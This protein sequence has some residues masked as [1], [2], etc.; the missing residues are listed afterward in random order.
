MMLQDTISDALMNSV[1]Q[2]SSVFANQGHSTNPRIGSN[3]ISLYI[4]PQMTPH[5]LIKLK[6]ISENK[7]TA[8]TMDFI[9]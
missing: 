7:I 3:G 9:I 4:Q 8:I 2:R 6:L 1:H 5:I